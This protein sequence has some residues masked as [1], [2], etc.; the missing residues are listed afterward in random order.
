MMNRNNIGLVSIIM[1]AFNA[2]KYIGE[3]I[4]SVMNQTFSNWEL[5]IAD[6]KST[7]NTIEKIKQF[8]DSRIRVIELSKNSGAAVAR[9]K[10]IERAKGSYLAFLDSDDLWHPEKLEKQLAFMLENNILFSSTKYANV[11]SKNQLL[12]V[13]MN[14]SVLDYNGVLK[15]CPGNSTV[16]YNVKELGKFYIP[17]IKKRN[18]FV[19]WLKVIKDAKN[20]YGLPEVLTYYRVREDGLSSNKS[21]LVKYQ[22]KVYREFEN[23]SVIKS[24]YLLVHKV[25]TVKFQLNK[26][27]F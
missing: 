3:S 12:D 4:Q 23:L 26:K 6:D 15:Y 18:D 19:M 21:N 10:A 2:E 22:W 1:P 24:I 13:T 17:D 25:V 5:I 11:N 14:H 27:D 8:N 7:D 9:N 16:M 20:L